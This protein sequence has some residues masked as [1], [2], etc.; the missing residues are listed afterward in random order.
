M[1]ARLAIAVLCLVGPARAQEAVAIFGASETAARSRMLIHGS[2][3]IA[4][5]APFL[6]RFAATSPGL[7]VIYQQWSTND[8]YAL[9]AEACAGGAAGADLL[10]SSSI[11]QQIKLVNDNCARA[12]VSALTR[13]LPGW[14]QWRNEVFGLTSE[15]AVMVYNRRLVPPGDVPRSRFDLIDLLRP[16]DTRYAGRV[17]TYDIER[18]GLGYLFA[19]LDSQQATTFGRLIE[20]FGRSE[21]VATCCSAE[22][23]DAV[24]EGRYLIG[25]NLLGSYALA[26]AARDDRI[27]VVAPSDYTLLLSRAALIPRHAGN[28]A[29]AARLIDFALSPTGKTLLVEAALIVRFT[30]AADEEEAATLAVEGSSLRPIAF[31]PAL[32]V[33]LDRHKRKLFVDLWRSSVR[34][35][36]GEPQ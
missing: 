4:A 6:E 33:G 19:F 34:P 15:P 21:A 14:A 8:I 1:I 32:L 36:R 2:T 20:A 18:S 13:E 25:Y 12:H 3:D 27:G 35:E 10:I 30:G 11:D 23:I 24:A 7:H 5:F 29:A 17:A 16:D 22:I 9:A 28:P 26:R 31:S